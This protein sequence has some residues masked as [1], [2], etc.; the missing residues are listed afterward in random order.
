MSATAG[1][2]EGT[3]IPMPT[4]PLELAATRSDMFDL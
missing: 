1:H 4:R 3:N 2:D